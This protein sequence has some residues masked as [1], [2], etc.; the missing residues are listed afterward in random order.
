MNHVVIGRVSRMMG[1]CKLIEMGLSDRP[2][3]EYL[4][5]EIRLLDQEVRAH[6]VRFFLELTAED[7]QNLTEIEAKNNQLF[8]NPTPK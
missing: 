1:L 6:A 2:Y 7:K 3:Q 8:I 5:E 4:A